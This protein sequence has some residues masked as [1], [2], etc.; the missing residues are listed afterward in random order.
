MAL[1][2]HTMVPAAVVTAQF[3]PQGGDIWAAKFTVHNDG[4][5]PSIRG[6]TIYFPESAF[7]TPSLANAPITWDTIV[8]QPRAIKQE[9]SAGLLNPSFRGVSGGSISRLSGFVKRSH[10][11]PDELFPAADTFVQRVGAAKVSELAK[12]IHDELKEAFKY[13]KSDLTLDPDVGS[14]TITTPDFDVTIEIAQ[15]PDD[16][17]DYAQAV[18]VRS[19]RDSSIVSDHRFQNVFSRHCNTLVIEFERQVS[20]SDRI[21]QIE[22]DDFLADYLTYEPDLSSLTL[23]LPEPRLRRSHRN[24]GPERPRYRPS[25]EEL[26]EGYRVAHGRWCS[27]ADQRLVQRGNS[28]IASEWRAKRGTVPIRLVV[29]QRVV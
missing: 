18:S 11:V 10:R 22:D 3:T 24:D 26:Q 13:K 20:V 9:L 8:V 5:L 25:F 27:P 15:A 6:F 1:V 16:H 21:D 23:E 12:S 28:G 14:A 19:F 7:S 4:T 17:K 2:S 29:R